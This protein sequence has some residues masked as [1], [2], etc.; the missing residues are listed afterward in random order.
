M[1]GYLTGSADVLCR[2]LTARLTAM[3]AEL[4]T[5]TPATRLEMDGQ[6]LSAVYSGDIRF[7][8]HRFLFTIPTTAIHPL[9]KNCDEPFAARLKAIEYCGAI[10]VVL[11]SKRPLSRIYWLNVADP[12]FPFGGVI[13]HTNFIDPSVYGH[14]HI[15]YLS[16]YFSADE[17]I[18]AQ[19]GE[20]IIGLML[21]ALRRLSPAF[22][23]SALEDVRIFRTDTAATL[24]DVNF[25][26]KV[27]A[28]R[29][30]IRNMYLAGMPHIYP[31]ER[32]CNNSVRVAAEA[33][34]VMEL[35]CPPLPRGPSLSG[36]VAMG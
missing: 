18:A 26:Q 31:D 21:S 2:A 24:C 8:A 30:P 19:S 36:Q 14:R 12:G 35:D 1:L 22:P 3:G 10:C 28:C 34:K 7:A 15:I 17:E 16:R 27:P 5:G 33:C 9:L 11:I 4:H 25:S 13:E 6:G 29:T 23:E 32:S 20:T